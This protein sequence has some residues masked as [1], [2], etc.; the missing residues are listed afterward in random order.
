MAE[1]PQLQL[2]WSAQLSVAAARTSLPG[3]K[4]LLPPSA[5]E[6]LLSASSNRAAENARR[7]LPAY[8]PYNSATYSAYRQAESQ[9]QDQK[10]QLPYP[11]T[12]RLVNPESGRVVYAGIREFS[13]EEGEV[14]LSPFLR[15]TLGLSEQQHESKEAS[16]TVDGEEG[17]NGVHRPTITV[18]ARQL[19]KGTFVKLRPLEAGY[20]PEDWKALLEQYLRQNYTT[21]TNGAVLIV[22]GGRGM[23]G[24]KEEFRFLV[25]G[26]K[27]DVDGV[28]IVDTDL[29]VDIEALNEEQARETL[30][31]IAAKMTK[32]PG[33]NHGSSVGGEMDL[34]KPQEGRVLPG[35]YVDY[36]LS[37]WG[38][39]QPLEIEL[40]GEDDGEVDLLVSPFSAT[41]RAKP[42]VDEHVFAE[43]E[44]RPTKRIRLEPSNVELENAEALYVSVHAFSA[45][46][47]QTNGTANGET[48]SS[49]PVHFTLTARHQD[50]A[51]KVSD[52][53]GVEIDAPPNEGDVRCK[54]CGQFVPQR[55]LMLHE[56][57]CLR[58]NILCPQGCGQVFQKRSPAFEAHWHCPHDTAYGN[59]TL[60]HQK[61][62]TL[63]HP[64]E[65]LHCSDCGTRETFPSLPAL[66]HHR[67]TTCPAKVI[68]CRFCHLE[69]PQEGDPDVPNAEALLSGLTP[70][71]LADG[72]RTTECHLCN[73]IVRLRDM[74]T[75]LKNHDLDRFERPAPHACRNANCG[76]TL[77][78]CS[79]SGDTRAGTRMGQ[80]PG[81]D[82]G[83]CSVCFGPL[84]V[85]MYDPEGKA[86]RRRIERRYLQQLVSGCG[87]AWCRNEYCKTGRQHLGVSGG[88][89]A[90]STKEALPMIKP[91]LDALAKGVKETSLHFCV[92]EKSQRQRMLAEMLAAEDGGVGGKGG[93]G[94]EWCVGAL[95][96]EGGDVDAARLWL[97]NWAPAKG[98]GRR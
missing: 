4:I 12:F 39:G 14:V 22:P 23:G 66:S 38:R 15:E 57:F 35:E 2:Q 91:F 6:A 49:G 76:R 61:H 95:E 19:D 25:D 67:T 41:Q 88:G 21:L 98:E 87:K 80:G 48:P 73:K 18:H 28:C 84:Y 17:V 16:M 46:E 30:K 51:A 79:H 24:K 90:V 86:L 34:F 63:F 97:R 78:V 56:N 40:A 31:R 32:L 11:L 42:R 92:D 7:D 26:F 64:T 9:Y 81:N 74:E 65:V 75:H 71:E 45:S 58:N 59:T 60:S 43:F 68:L 83:L 20:D 10:Q 93:Y 62:D 85:S 96:A 37:S 69:V 5:L 36:R 82:I 13:A 54:N 1:Q 70:H 47:L 33:S 94:L 77:D 44:G 72:A 53:Q 55:T 27:P 52:T 3:D 50:A 89:T 29:E 8:D